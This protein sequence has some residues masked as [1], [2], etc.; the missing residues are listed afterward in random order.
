MA[1]E[2]YVDHEVLKT[3]AGNKVNVPREEAKERRRQV[4]HLRERLESYIADHPDFDLVKLRASGSTAKHTAI[5]RRSGEGSDA[6][7]AAYLRVAD[8][9]VDV[10]TVLDWLR[11]RCIEVYGKTKVADDFVPS[12]HA[13]GITMR[14]TGLKI[15]VV[16]VLYTGEPDDKGYLVTSKGIKVLTSV[17]LHL[18]FMRKRKDAVGDAYRE[19]IRLLKAWIRESKITDPDL[20]CKSFLL[21]LLVAHL[22]ETGWNGESL[23]VNDYPR[24]IEQVL[25]YIVRTGLQQPIVFTDYY[26]ANEIAHSWAPIQVWDPVNPENNVTSTYTELDR[27][28]LVKHAKS[29]LDTVAWAAHATTKGDANDAWRELF[30]PSFPGA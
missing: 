23:Q 5:R 3:F 6:D 9:K 28:R 27:Q 12:D 16:P 30:G 21:E 15:D 29:T 19:L 2:P 14:G 20:R 4:N 17:T 25:S 11:D 7:V 8:P 22:W 13:V 10:S 1:G 26:E 18:Q 24:A